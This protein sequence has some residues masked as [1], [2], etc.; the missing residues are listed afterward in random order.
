MVA[1]RRFCGGRKVRAPR[2]AWWVTPI[3]VS[4]TWHEDQSYSDDASMQI[5]E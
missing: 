2:A 3:H 1:R 4:A 5:E